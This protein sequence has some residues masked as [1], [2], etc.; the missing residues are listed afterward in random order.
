M[1]RWIQ[2]QGAR[3]ERCWMVSWS[4]SS[5]SYP[6]PVLARPMTLPPCKILLSFGEG[7]G[8]DDDRALDDQLHRRADAEQHQT[9]VE[10]ADDQAAEQRPQDEAAPAEQAAA[11]E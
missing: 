7:D 2:R 4:S 5:V 10:R 11:A 1:P 3:S 9:V 8:S 6:S